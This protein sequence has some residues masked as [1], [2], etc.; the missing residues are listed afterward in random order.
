MR[1]QTDRHRRDPD[2]GGALRARLTERAQDND[3]EVIVYCVI[4]LRGDESAAILEGHGRRNVKVMEG[5]VAAWPSP[6]ER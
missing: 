5:G 6:R 4:S 2:P 1:G 3:R